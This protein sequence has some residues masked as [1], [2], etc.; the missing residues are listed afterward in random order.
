MIKS[1]SFA[2]RHLIRAQSRNPS[3][4]LAG[5]R[6][7]NEPYP[8]CYLK[9]V[10]LGS[11]ELKEAHIMPNPYECCVITGSCDGLV[12]VYGIERLM[13]IINPATRW[14]RSFPRP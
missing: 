2:S 14:F 9:K 4:L 8:F 11:S 5:A 7:W 10:E 1:T 12:C 3:I 13:C 6:A